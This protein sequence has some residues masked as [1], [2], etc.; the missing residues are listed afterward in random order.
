[1]TREHKLSLV[2]GFSVMLAVGVLISDHLSSASSA[3]LDGQ[4]ADQ[5]TELALEQIDVLQPI[6]R[7]TDLLAPP[8]QNQTELALGI[9]EQAEPTLEDLTEPVDSGF[10][11]TIIAQGTDLADLAEQISQADMP[12]AAVPGRINS[13]PPART[14]VVRA[15]DT[16]FSIAKTYYGTGHIWRQL[17]AHNADRVGPNG[18]LDL[19]VALIIPPRESLL[20][21][22]IPSAP[23][24]RPESTPIATPIATPIRTPIVTAT[25]SPTPQPDAVASTYTVQPGDTLG[26]ISQSRLGTVKRMPDL[27]ALNDLDE[28]DDIRVGMVL[29]LPAR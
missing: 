19:D 13:A 1:M 21:D 24:I 3:R 17:Q 22:P 9:L 15:D 28:P 7:P 23:A 16:L 11:T 25:L 27:I 8:E 14:H 26:A 20:G 18:E 4:Q 5:P 6:E 10:V 29:K 2:I 12:V